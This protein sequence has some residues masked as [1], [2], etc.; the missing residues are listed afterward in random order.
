[1]V[2]PEQLAESGSEHAHQV[3]FFCWCATNL[4]MVHNRLIFAIPNGGK[5]DKITSG[6]LKAEGVKA[7]VADIFVS[8][9]VGKYHGLYIELKKP[10]FKG[11][12]RGYVEPE[13]KE[14]RTGVIQQGYAH[15]ICVGWRDAVDILMKY[16]KG[17]YVQII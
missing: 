17:E 7:G 16:W 10:A 14:F 11:K 8:I 3:A 4:M 1:M 12:R 2:T 6:N 5:R 15:A 9:P 13:Q